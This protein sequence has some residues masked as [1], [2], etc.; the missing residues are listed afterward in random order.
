MPTLCVIATNAIADGTRGALTRWLLEPHA[1]VYVG[2]LTA[3]V[4]EQLWNGVRESINNQGG[5]AVLIHTANTEQG[6]ALHT[7][8]TGR[9]TPID[10]DGLTLLNWGH[11]PKNITNP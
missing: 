5:W 7:C 10:L 4:R 3:R 11:P 2:T 8:G 1:G 9:R 6:F